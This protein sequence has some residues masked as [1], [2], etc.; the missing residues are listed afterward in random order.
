MTFSCLCPEHNATGPAWFAARADANRLTLDAGSSGAG[1]TPLFHVPA[2]QRHVLH[3]GAE[4]E[5]E[6][7]ADQRDRTYRRIQDRIGHHSRNDPPGR[8][9]LPRFPNQVARPRGPAAGDPDYQAALKLLVD[10]ADLIPASDTGGKSRTSYDR[11]D[12]A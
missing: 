10:G 12:P 11:A 9:E 3:V 2:Q 8:T 6:G 4:H 5:V 7:V 1:E